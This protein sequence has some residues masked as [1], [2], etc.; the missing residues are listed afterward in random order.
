MPR[1]GQFA[2]VRGPVEEWQ[3]ER[4]AGTL[5]QHTQEGQR[6]HTNQDQRVTQ[7]KAFCL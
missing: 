7:V 2:G 5:H 4:A 1:S 3:E 6:G